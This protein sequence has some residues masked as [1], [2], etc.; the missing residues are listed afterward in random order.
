MI[1]TSYDPEAD[2]AFVSFGP[3]GAQSTETVEVAP[4]ILLDYDATGRVIGVEVLD[5][6]ARAAA[7][8]PRAQETV[9]A[10]QRR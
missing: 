2:A 8:E 3:K 7:A 9:A 5:V 10:A 6:R 4:G 1:T